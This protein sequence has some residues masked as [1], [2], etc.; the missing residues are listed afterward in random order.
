MRFVCAGWFS[1]PLAPAMYRW[2]AEDVEWGNI[3]GGEQQHFSQ[4]FID[5]FAGN[6]MGTD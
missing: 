4:G 3:G 2:L 5:F 6:D 1:L